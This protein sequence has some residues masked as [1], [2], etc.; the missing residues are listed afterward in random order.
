MTEKAWKVFFEVHSNL[1]RQGPGDNE[2]TKKA[3]LMLPDLPLKPRILD[4]GC[5]S[6]MQTI[7]LAELSNGRVEALDNYPPF[8]EQLKQKIAEA[9]VSDR[10]H[11]V[12]GSMF[13]IAYADRSFDVIWSEGAIFIIG[14]E[15]GLREWKR[16]LKPRGF[17][18]VSEI[19]WLKTNQPAQVAE[20]LAQFWKQNYPALSTIEENL[21]V[22]KKAGY[23]VVGTFVLPAESWWTSYYTPILEKLPSL[24]QKYQGDPEA[25]SVLAMEDAETETF[26]KYSAYYGYVFYILQTQA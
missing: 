2:S 25:L 13:D 6:G 12:K 22:A 3:Y 11:A 7:E 19:S 5:G 16:L 14:F 4:I 10:V 18:V 9:N 8:L 21:A 26:R 17:L 24:K 1:P 15:K 23:S 20:D